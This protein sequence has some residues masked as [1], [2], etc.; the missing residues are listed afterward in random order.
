[1]DTAEITV[2]EPLSGSHELKFEL[3][4]QRA[5]P[6]R[7]FLDATFRPDPDFPAGHVSTIYFD[8]P[9]LRFLRE[10]ANSDHLKSK[11]RLRWYDDAASGPL[12]AEIKKKAGGRRL[13]QRARVIARAAD[14]VSAPLESGA[15]RSVIEELVALAAI[16]TGVSPIL[17]INYGRRRYV[18][19]T[20]G[21]RISLDTQIRVTRI[22]TR[23]LSR[24]DPL[25]LRSAVLEV[26]GPE[27]E[28]LRRLGP[29]VSFGCHRAAFSKYL[30]CYEKACA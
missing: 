11:A 27:A 24:F 20:T 3:K 22:N 25:P 15:Y 2:S 12:F 13:K 4:A 10:K 9:N 30:R 16:P 19:T 21:S 1:M 29:L 7:A 28:P 26:K 6:A 23:L 5:A 14:L 17:Q 8:T 18:D